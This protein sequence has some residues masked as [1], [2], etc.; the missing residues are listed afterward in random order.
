MNRVLTYISSTNKETARVVKN[1]DEA[2]AFIH[3]LG[4]VLN[5]VTEEN[6][7]MLFGEL[8]SNYFEY[9]FYKRGYEV[10]CL[11]PVGIST[12]WIKFAP[13]ECETTEE[14]VDKEAEKNARYDEA[15]KNI[16]AAAKETL[17]RLAKDS[18]HML[19]YA[20]R[21]KAIKER[22]IRVDMCWD[23]VWNGRDG[24]DYMSSR[25][26]TADLDTL[27]VEDEEINIIDY[28]NTIGK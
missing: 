12:G 1:A 5:E 13:T 17:A 18:K 20:D 26:V 3:E 10:K 27:K 19:Y 21:R 15:I 28:L 8:E 14:Y 6:V 2:K 23:G 4:F 22:T 7:E 9:Y 24:Y 25:G 11:K 16:L